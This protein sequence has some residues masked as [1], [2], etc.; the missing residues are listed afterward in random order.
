MSG[1]NH[2]G[3]ER[4][5]LRKKGKAPFLKKKKEKKP[6]ASGLLDPKSGT[7]LKFSREGNL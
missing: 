1:I 4:K 6:Q 2:R 3:R 7:L 5:A